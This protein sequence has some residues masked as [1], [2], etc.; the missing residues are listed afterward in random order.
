MHLSH[1]EP[2]DH[3]DVA[4]AGGVKLLVQLAGD[5]GLDSQQDAGQQ[6]GVGLGQV[7]A[8]VSPARALKV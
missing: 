2:G 8:M 1:V 5:A 7:W 3:N 4:G 6:G